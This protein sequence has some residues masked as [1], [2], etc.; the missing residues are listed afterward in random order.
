M[1]SI[2]KA[3]SIISIQRIDLLERLRKTNDFPHAN[4]FKDKSLYKIWQ[5][6]REYRSGTAVEGI[7]IIQTLKHL[8]EWLSFMLKPDKHGIYKR[9]TLL[10]RNDQIEAF[11]NQVLPKLKAIQNKTRQISAEDMFQERLGVAFNLM[12]KGKF[13]L[14]KKIKGSKYTSVFPKGLNIAA[15]PPEVE[16][17]MEALNLKMHPGSY[18]HKVITDHL[19]NASRRGDALVVVRKYLNDKNR[20]MLEVIVWDNGGETGNLAGASRDLDFA[21][22]Y[23]DAELTIPQYA[24][25]EIIFESGKQR[26]ERKHNTD[27]H[28]FTLSTDSIHGTRITTRFWI[29]Q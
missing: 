29:E 16:G 27:S 23:L 2:S 26:V 14:I 28:H 10:Y 4:P 9:W 3:T 24:A 18:R 6:S 20:L 22:G 12:R 11:K 13:G 19:K 5:A 1:S 25:D 17:L 7:E 8:I 21:A 15:N